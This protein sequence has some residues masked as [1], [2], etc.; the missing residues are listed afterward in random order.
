MLVELLTKDMDYHIR[1]QTSTSNLP[2]RFR[3]V[4][5]GLYDVRYGFILAGED[6]NSVGETATGPDSSPGFYFTIL[7]GF[8]EHLCTHLPE[9]L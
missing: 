7:E 3:S 5:Y 6:R 4:S 8:K 9:L 2:C 1:F